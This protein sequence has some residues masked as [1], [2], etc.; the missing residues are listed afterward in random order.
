MQ[1]LQTASYDLNELY[2]IY[3]S[4]VDLNS[5]LTATIWWALSI[6]GYLTIKDF[7]GKM[8]TVSAFRMA[9]WG[10]FYGVSGS[11]TMRVAPQVMTFVRWSWR[12]RRAADAFLTRIRRLLASVAADMQP[13]QGGTQL[14]QYAVPAFQGDGVE[15]RMEDPPARA[16][17]DM[18]VRT[19]KYTSM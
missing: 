13:N 19:D 2:G 15:V 11:P 4:E 7:D 5:W 18:V 3:A 10:R 9:R 17:F 8:T 6:S 12:W 1:L 16:A 14:P